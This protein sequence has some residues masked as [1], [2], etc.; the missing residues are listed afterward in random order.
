MKNRYFAGICP[1]SRVT[2]CG[3]QKEGGAS[4]IVPENRQELTIPSCDA[5]TEG[6]DS[7]YQSGGKDLG[8]KDPY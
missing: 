4:D 7:F 8:N 5:G 2:G 1:G 6:F 3:V